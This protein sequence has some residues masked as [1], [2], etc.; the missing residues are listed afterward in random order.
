MNTKSE[1]EDQARRQ[2][3]Q[4]WRLLLTVVLLCANS[5]IL[6]SGLFADFTASVGATGYVNTLV[7]GGLVFCIFGAMRAANLFSQSK[8]LLNQSASSSSSS[9]K[10][11]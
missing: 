8:K 10:L 6:S 2:R 1:L 4:A 7:F 5:L 11:G 9:E 3:H